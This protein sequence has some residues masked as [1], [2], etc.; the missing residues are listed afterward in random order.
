MVCAAVWLQQRSAYQK[1]ERH[2]Q[3]QGYHWYSKGVLKVYYLGVI[4]QIYYKMMPYKDQCLRLESHYSIKEKVKTV[5][6]ISSIVAASA[7][8]TN[9]YN[10]TQERK[11]PFT[12]MEEM[13]LNKKR[14]AYCSI[15]G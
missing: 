14:G 7:S 6:S 15:K 1:L 9:S 3:F 8:N 2:V 5:D 13:L 11:H 12:T 10:N 4:F